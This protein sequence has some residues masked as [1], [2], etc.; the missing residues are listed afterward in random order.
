MS[1][2]RRVIDDQGAGEL[3]R[4]LLRA[5]RSA[6]PDADAEKRLLMVLSAVPLGALPTAVGAGK[7]TL[8]GKL[9]SLPA[10]KTGL[11]LL[12]GAVVAGGVYGAGRWMAGPGTS[13]SQAVGVSVGRA[14]VEPKEPSSGEDAE[15]LTVRAPPAPDPS[16]PEA[17]DEDAQP[18]P[19]GRPA[20]APRRMRSA[21][22]RQALLDDESSAPSTQAALPGD[23]DAPT[24][25]QV[26]RDTL[27]AAELHEL[28][29][30]RGALERGDPA[31][32]RRRLDAYFTRFDHGFL[33]PE[34]ERLRQ[35]LHA[36]EESP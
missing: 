13:E 9:F 12:G 27:L 2:A 31:E 15:P 1:G 35:R 22:A 17:P 6:E 34:A 24:S 26:A 16:E 10:V 4:L 8:A 3:G 7:A 25:E 36:V 19:V 23:R 11:F 28:D 32:A 21:T 5:G 29:A 33:Q 18:A 30:A 20:A 14:R